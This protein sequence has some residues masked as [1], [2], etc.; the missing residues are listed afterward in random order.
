MSPGDSATA[1]VARAPVAMLVVD[2]RGV[3]VEANREVERLFGWADQQLIGSTVEVLV[4]GPM[5]QLHAE[6]R[7]EYSAAPRTRTMGSRSR[8]EARHRDGHLFSVDVMLA[9]LDE[10]R[11]L[12][13]VVDRSELGVAEDALRRNSATF[14]HVLESIPDVVYVV[15]TQGSDAL[16]AR[17]ELVSDHVEAVVGWAAED[18]MRDPGLWLRCIHPDD[19]P[20]LGQ[21]TQEM[22]ASGGPVIRSYRLAHKNG[23]DWRQMEDRASL[24]R[25]MRGEITGYCGVARDVT[26]QRSREAHAAMKERVAALGLLCASV[27]H[28]LSNPLTY[29]LASVDLAQTLLAE[30]PEEIARARAALGD[31]LDGLGRMRAILADLTQMGRQEESPGV[32][33]VRRAIDLAARIAAGALTERASLRRKY[34]EIPLVRGDETRLVQ[35]FLNLLINA[36]QAMPKERHGDITVSVAPGSGAEVV[37][38]VA[39]DGEGI[40]AEALPHIFDAFFT[41]KPAGVGTGLGLYVCRALVREMGGDV[42]VES[43]LGKGTRVRVV[44][45]A[46]LV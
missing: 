37:V 24:L 26:E 15:R 1:L 7:S 30:R 39:D 19:L 25:D 27:S 43:E 5:R 11:T 42:G 34:A 46:V 38:E 21:R 23:S 20:A 22:F 33:D 2:A 17:V 12:T 45:P 10:G 6:R 36:A 29:V 18:F 32:A 44:L 35:V 41:T 4:P 8:L 31:A 14:R 3:I 16:S 28:E 13:V 40:A 9:P